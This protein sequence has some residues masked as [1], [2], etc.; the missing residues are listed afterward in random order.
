MSD[1]LPLKWE[2]NYG[3]DIDPLGRNIQIF[4][5]PSNSNEILIFQDYHLETT[6]VFDI[7]NSS[8]KSYT[9]SLWPKIL[10]EEFNEFC[11]QHAEMSCSNITFDANPFYLI[12]NSTKSGML[13]IVGRVNHSSFYVL[14]DTTKSILHKIHQSYHFKFF[15]NQ[16]LTPILSSLIS[17]KHF[18][19]ILGVHFCRKAE[20][21]DTVS[22]LNVEKPHDAKIVQCVQLTKN[23][24][25][26]HKESFLMSDENDIV[27]LVVFG[28]KMPDSQD[29]F[30]EISIDF[31]TQQNY[32]YT[33]DDEPDIQKNLA[34]AMKHCNNKTLIGK[35]CKGF[36]CHW[37]YKKRYLILFGEKA[38]MPKI[39]AMVGLLDQ[40]AAEKLYFMMQ[41]TVV[42]II[43]VINYHFHCQGNIE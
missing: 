42:G 2:C 43:V 24:F 5:N 28:G 4:S 15:V 41:N 13:S 40:T 27:K 30:C 36:Q 6:Y 1:T 23:Y 14:L 39:D 7:I 33:I 16:I 8:F 21:P 26:H 10:F 25:N 29:S 3:L 17:Y 20:P 12:T 22:I 37:W 9:L 19:I 18:R 35:V 38:I 32:N 11:S 34:A 31:R